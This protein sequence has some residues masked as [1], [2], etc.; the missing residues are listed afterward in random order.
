MDQL[1]ERALTLPLGEARQQVVAEFERRYVRGVL[2]RHSGNV[3]HAAD[4]A[5]VA[6]R[7]FQILKARLEKRGGAPAPAVTQTPRISD[8]PES[9]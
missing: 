5:G 9:P 3:T 7:Y 1:I 2:H 4:S 6:R 8:V